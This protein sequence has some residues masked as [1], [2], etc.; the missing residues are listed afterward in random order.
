MNIL[1][2][3][4][5]GREHA[6]AYKIKQSPL[7]DSLFIAPGNVGT[8]EFGKNIAIQVTEF[9]AIKEFVLSNQIEMVVVGP[10]DPLVLGVFDFFAND[11]DLKNIQIIGPSQK[12]AMLEGSKSFAKKFMQRNKIPTASYFEVSAENLEE[13]LNYLDQQKMPI[14]LKADGLAAGKGVLI[15]NSVAEAKAELNAMI[16]ES[17]F[18]KA[19]A[20]VVIESFLKGIEFSVFVLTDGKDYILLPNA[21]D[22]KRI[23]END[24]GLNT[25]GMGCISPVPFVD[26]AIMEKVTNQIILPTINGLQKEEIVYHGFIYFGI[27]NVEGNPFVIEYNCRLGDPETEVIL[28]RLSSD[29]VQHFLA[30]KNGTL[31]SEKTTINKEAAATVIMASGGYPENFNKG[32]IIENIPTSAAD[33]K[34]FFA[35]VKAEGGALLTNGGRVLAVTAFGKDICEAV[36]KS[37]AICEQINFKDKYYRKDI[38]WEFFN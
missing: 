9:E 19:S 1:L 38:G 21:K 10:E 14:V 16:N 25:G 18:G 22:Y 6:L 15:L 33:K 26:E 17:K 31:L 20:K 3:G 5:G 34:V 7:C 24:T 4:S 13:G 12:G 30:I 37:N 8:A 2:L 32:F 23:G 28:P 27:I 11:N 29:L 36:A 35:G